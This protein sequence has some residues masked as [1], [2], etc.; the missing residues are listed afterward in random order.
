MSNTA[1]LT[2]MGTTVA[3]NDDGLF[4]L[5]DL[6]KASGGE[7]KNQPKRWLQ[8]KRTKNVIEALESEQNKDGNSVLKSNKK[9]GTFVNRVLVYSYAMHVSAV[10]EIEVT[11]AFDKQAQKKLSLANLHGKAEWQQNRELGKLTHRKETDVIKTFLAYAGAQGSNNYPKH[12]YSLIAKMVNAALSIEDRDAINEDTLHL[13]S[14]AE[15]IAENAIT[16]GMN[17]GLPYKVI[18]QQAKANV[19]SF[20]AMA[21]PFE[22]EA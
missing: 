16:Q 5:N 20:A 2:L 10:F 11:N 6:W 17:E 8:L 3:I 18:F 4:S 12:G 22:L 19:I 14:T 21:I 13:L 1:E 9:A 15:K 7:P